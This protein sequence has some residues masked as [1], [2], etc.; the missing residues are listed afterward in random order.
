MQIINQ[1][2]N[3]STLPA[4]NKF[5]LD[6]ANSDS[7][8]LLSIFAVVAREC[9][10]RFLASAVTLQN[11]KLPLLRNLKVCRSKLSLPA[12]NIYTEGEG[13]GLISPL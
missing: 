1:T 3:K 2:P 7:K 11:L 6:G 8:Y 4:P 12:D 10:E 5:N 13:A 9:H